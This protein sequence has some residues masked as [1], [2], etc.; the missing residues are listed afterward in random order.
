MPTTTDLDVTATAPAPVVTLQLPTDRVMQ[1]FAKDPATGTWYATQSQGGT[2]ES[3]RVFRLTPDG[4][5]IDYA[6]LAGAG[7]GTNLAI[8]SDSVG[9][10][11]VWLYWLSQGKTVRWWYTG[12]PTGK[13]VNWGDPAI[14]VYTSLEPRVSQYAIDQQNGYIASFT[15]MP[16][17]TTEK[18]VL[19]RLADYK[20]GIDAPLAT[21]GPLDWRQYG[22]DQ[23]FC[24]VDD[25][26]FIN[27]GGQNSLNPDDVTPHIYQFDWDTGKFVAGVDVTSAGTTK[28]GQPIGGH[29]ESEGMSVWRDATGNPQIL[30]GTAV[31]TTD[32][33]GYVAR[34]SSLSPSAGGRKRLT[35]DVLTA[36]LSPA[37][38]TTI[39]VRV[40]RDVDVQGIGRVAAKNA[41]TSYTIGVDG[42]FPV[43]DVVPSD[44][45]A[46]QPWSKGYALLVDAFPGPAAVGAGVV[47][48][49]W[50]LSVTRANDAQIRLT[51]FQ[52]RNLV[53]E[54]LVDV[55]AIL[56]QLA[57]VSGT[58]ND[59]ITEAQDALTRAA[60][61][62]AT[63]TLTIAP[64]DTQVAGLAQQDNT[65]PAGMSQTRMALDE[66]FV[67]NSDT[68]WS[69]TALTATSN[70]SGWVAH[71]DAASGSFGLRVRGQIVQLAAGCTYIGETRT[72]DGGG[73][74]GDV[75]LG[76]IT[77]LTLRPEVDEEVMVFR[78]GISAFIGRISSAGAITLTGGTFPGESI[79][80][81]T[82]IRV[83]CLWVKR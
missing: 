74:F 4:T 9:G 32:G 14:T 11:W 64:T 25:N 7:H 41:V 78:N 67:A 66:L 52:G 33:T 19:R 27:R 40:D 22:V 73:N 31:G 77:D 59:A 63:A 45:P 50:S 21:V 20:A 55:Q 23:G 71:T 62:L 5:V 6:D 72:A 2:P 61:A 26:L 81:G 39:T 80:G 18:W 58:S 28:D 38:G 8:E 15:R 51:D 12:S 13:T 43:V 16:G 57:A 35:L 44:S 69:T 24:T 49:T 76:T 37:V 56:D 54:S 83:E 75:L 79:V 65:N 46:L 36:D 3:F 30:F 82:N 1:G 60:A 29:N 47:G 68:G 53:P 34:V 70:I 17:N 10:V 42:Q 48:G